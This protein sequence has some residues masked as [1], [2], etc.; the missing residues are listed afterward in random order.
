MLAHQVTRMIAYW[1]DGNDDELDNQSDESFI[2]MAPFLILMEPQLMMTLLW[3]IPMMILITI[4]NY[5]LSVTMRLLGFT[6]IGTIYSGVG[7]TAS[8]TKWCV[9]QFH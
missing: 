5:F 7:S 8:G 2:L 6:F 4:W 3:L 9:H 1:S